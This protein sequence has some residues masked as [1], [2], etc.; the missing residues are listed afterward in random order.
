MKVLVLPQVL[1]FV[2]T[3]TSDFFSTVPPPVAPRGAINPS[4]PVDTPCDPR[5]FRACPLTEVTLTALASRHR[6]FKPLPA[7]TV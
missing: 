6:K 3:G 1:S 2:G 5:T 7:G 4:E